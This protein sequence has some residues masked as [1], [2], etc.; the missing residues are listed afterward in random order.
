[1]A[2]TGVRDTDFPLKH[3][4]DRVGRRLGKPASSGSVAGNGAAMLPWLRGAGCGPKLFAAG[5]AGAASRLPRPTPYETQDLTMHESRPNRQAIRIL[6]LLMAAAIVFPLGLFSYA[7]LSNYRAAWHRA[8]ERIERGLDV[9]QEHTLKVLETVARTFGEVSAL[10][11]DKSDEQLTEAEARLHARLK[12]IAEDLPQVLSIW[13]IDSAGRTAASS[14]LHPVGRTSAFAS[15]DYFL[16]QVDASRPGF[17]GE[18]F[19]S[20]IDQVTLFGMSTRRP[21]A[22]GSFRGIILVTVQPDAI[23]TFY[24]RLQ[25]G[26]ADQIGLLRPDGSF[27]VR[28]PPPRQPSMTLSPASGFRR[29]IAAAPESGR[30]LT[31]GESDGVTRQFGYRKLLGYPLYITAAVDLDA[32]RAEVISQMLTHLIFGVPATI[33]LVAITYV[34]LRRTRGF[35]EETERR[36]LAEATLKQAQ[37]ME[38]VGQLTGGVAHDFNNLLMVISGNVDR[39]RRDRTDPTSARSLDAIEM[40]ARRGTSLTR[41]LLS[42]S[43]RQAH[44]PIAIDLARRLLKMRDML[45]SSLRGDIALAVD[46]NYGVW[47]VK[48]DPAEFELALLNLAVN[49]RDAMPSGGTFTIRTSN[50]PASTVAPLGLKGDLVVITV[51]DTG[52]GIAPEALP[53]VFE[54]FFTTKEAGSGTGLGLSQIYGFATQSGGGVTAANGPQG[55][56]V[57]TLYL[58]RSLDLPIVEP[59][60]SPKAATT[61]RSGAAL[62]VE[63]NADVAEITAGMFQSL[64]FTTQLA[65]NADAALAAL[66]A[67][68]S[69]AVV[70][71]DIV[72]PGGKS[73]L[74]LARELRERRPDLPVLLASGYSRVA[75]EAVAEGFSI[76]AKPYSVDDLARTLDTALGR[77]RRA[78]SAPSYAGATFAQS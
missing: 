72:M 35:Y 57:I 69:I 41:Q 78:P 51:M 77:D 13:I 19:V 66:A 30:Y 60:D 65:E 62:V 33:L 50:L 46:I 29:S 27:L 18:L 71:S 5:L 32:I 45:Q 38:A 15:R 34:A 25:G 2:A 52:P 14:R 8:D 11:E 36:E 64:G 12:Q 4:R 47:P 53:H 7:A 21:S 28:Q 59:Q 70:F 76:L 31:T 74:D 56:A 6:Q 61:L 42:F 68:P 26:I 22:D 10:I 48:V 75:Q 16:A 40:A 67:D 20:L 37:R 17:I 49:S 73:G 63:D 44:K 3:R 39:L 23:R 54:P 58:P 1:M 9:V 24:A 43:R 55:G